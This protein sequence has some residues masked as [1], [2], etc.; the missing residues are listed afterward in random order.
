[1]VLSRTEENLI[2]YKLPYLGLTSYILAYGLFTAKFK[3]NYFAKTYQNKVIRCFL[4]VAL[5]VVYIFCIELFYWIIADFGYATKIR[6]N[7]F[8]SFPFVPSLLIMF[9]LYFFTH[10][11][12]LDPIPRKK[13]IM[14]MFGLPLVIMQ[15]TISL[16][17]D[18]CFNEANAISLYLG[19]LVC[20]A[21]PFVIGSYKA[22]IEYL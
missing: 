21:Y 14:A 4:F 6:A 16:Y 19:V 13:K 5:L 18:Y 10:Q 22:L 7:F 3:T 12:Y 9:S 11:R 8:F 2:W 17:T 1:M 15:L 20:A